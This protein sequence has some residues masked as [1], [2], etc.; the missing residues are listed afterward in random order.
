MSQSLPLYEFQIDRTPPAAV[1]EILDEVS[2]VLS[3]LVPEPNKLPLAMR[4][5]WRTALGELAHLRQRATH[6]HREL[7]SIETA[8]QNGSLAHEA[9]RDPCGDDYARLFAVVYPLLHVA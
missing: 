7:N 5:R 1:T 6:A 4:E 9:S 8:I 2:A 3:E